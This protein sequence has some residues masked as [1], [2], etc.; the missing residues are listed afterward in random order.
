[1]DIPRLI[2]YTL[3]TPKGLT[4]HKNGLPAL[5]MFLNA[6]LYLYANVYY[7]RTSRAIDLHLL[8]IF[9]ETMECIFPHNPLHHM[10]KYLRLTDWSLLETVRTWESSSNRKRQRIGKEWA[11]VLGRQVKW[12]NGVQQGADDARLPSARTGGNTGKAG[13]PYSS[14][15]TSATARADIPSGH[16]QQGY[17]ALQRVEH[18]PIS[19]L[20]LRS[21]NRVR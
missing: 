1:M 16:R 18:G 17:P 3:I 10:Q 7:H 15:I 20:S 5:Q 19:V 21:R 12:K 11:R 2:H 8:E 13:V 14:A 9:H 6:R 4:I